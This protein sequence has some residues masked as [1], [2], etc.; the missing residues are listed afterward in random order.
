MFPN[1]PAGWTGVSH[2]HNR[3]AGVRG[4]M[5]WSHLSSSSLPGCFL[6][7]GIGG[8]GKKD[9]KEQLDLVTMNNVNV[10]VHSC[11]KMF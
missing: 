9:G 10:S 7:V 5:V 11:G 8:M 6:K 2:N 1:Y 4:A 3:G